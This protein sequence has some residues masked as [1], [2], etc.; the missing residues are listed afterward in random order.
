MIRLSKKAEYALLALSYLRGHRAEPVSA[1]DIAAHFHIPPAILAKV[2]QSLKHVGIVASAK[3]VAGGYT[4][5]ADL[6]RVTFLELLDAFE[7]T[8]ALVECLSDPHPTCQ[9]LGCCGIRDP[10]AALNAVIQHQ[11]EGLTLEQLFELETVSA[12][13]AV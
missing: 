2:M 10:I 9:Q 11:L 6:G 3:G 7:E 1:A 5:D 13:H 8:T 4:L 12:T